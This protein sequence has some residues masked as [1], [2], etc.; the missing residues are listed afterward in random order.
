MT[1]TVRPT[2]RG[3]EILDRLLE[4]YKSKIPEVKWSKHTIAKIALE[5]GLEF[6]DKIDRQRT[7]PNVP[8]EEELAELLKRIAVS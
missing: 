8:D 5:H 1:V 7:R 2:V 3:G 4:N 6:L